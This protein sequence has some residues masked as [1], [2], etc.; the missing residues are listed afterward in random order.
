MKLEERVSAFV[1]LG[2]ELE[3]VAAGNP[4]TAAGKKLA[5]MIPEF[6][7]SHGWY[8]AENIRHRL[9]EL[10][11]SNKNEVLEK[12][13]NAYALKETSPKNI[14]VILAGNIPLVGFDDYRAVL[15]AGHKFI[16]KLSSDDKILLPL[17]H[18]ML[19]E[20]EPRFENAAV[21]LEGRLPAIDAVIATGSNN[22]ARYFEYY[23]SKYPHIIR[24][25]RNSVAVLD[26]TETDAELT[27]LGEDIFRY[28]GLGCRSVTK[29]FIPR[30]YDVGKVFA[31]VLPWG[32]KMINNKKYINNYE[33]HR[34]VYMLN[35]QALLDNN[36]LLLKE[37]AGISSPPGVLFYEYYD[38]LPQL[39]KKLSGDRELIQCI[40]S[41][42][43]P[44]AIP[45]G[46]TQETMP[47]D[48][49]DA[50]DVLAFLGGIGN[51]EPGAG[52]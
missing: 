31:A 38:E 13:L 23:F 18:Q 20:I 29:I 16:G 27:A 6:Y 9:S 42:N 37:D 49:A 3:A 48:Y 33:Y 44:G 10:A 19:S 24:K 14:A 40:V 45:F 35:K 15:I 1:Y 30:G 7:L 12:W 47:W 41:K 22:S 25:N 2:R 34:T 26:G 50:V 17:V 11:A 51:R 21:F 52:N 4:G 46:T 5:E 36:F 8:T 43:F 28:F 39:R 32:E